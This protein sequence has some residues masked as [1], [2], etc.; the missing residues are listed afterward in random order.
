MRYV[1]SGI[2]GHWIRNSSLLI[3]DQVVQRLCGQ[4]L[5]KPLLIDILKSLHIS[6]K[7]KHFEI[8]RIMLPV[9]ETLI[10]N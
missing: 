4:E 3:W 1:E 5:T 2:T 9:I 8:L 10:P 6:L 7:D